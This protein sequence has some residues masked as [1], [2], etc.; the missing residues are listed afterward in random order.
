MDLSDRT[1]LFINQETGAL[2]RLTVD[3]GRFRVAGGPGLV[4]VTKDR[5]RRWATRCTSFGR[6]F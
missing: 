2:M 6:R 1:G 4:V 5:F 3:R